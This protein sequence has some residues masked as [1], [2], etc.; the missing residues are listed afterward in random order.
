MKKTFLLSAAGADGNGNKADQNDILAELTGM[1]DSLA[2][3]NLNLPDL[4]SQHASLSANKVTVEGEVAK[5]TGDKTKL[6]AGATLP[7]DLVSAANTIADL[8]AK[9]S[10]LEG[11]KL[12]VEEAAAK[13]LV[14]LGFTDAGKQGDKSGEAKKPLT[15]TE[16]VLAAQGCKTLAESE[17]KFREAQAKN[18]TN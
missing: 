4:I 18:P 1:K 11:E 16:K 14:A 2:K 6:V 17:Q 3:I 12:S 7:T 15:L 9:V 8:T 13:K 5:L 10:K